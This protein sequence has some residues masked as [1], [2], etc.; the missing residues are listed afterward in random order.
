[1]SLSGLVSVDIIQTPELLGALVCV[2]VMDC[3]RAV[4]T[5]CPQELCPPFIRCRQL[6]MVR[7]LSSVHHLPQP[8]TKRLIRP[9][10]GS[11]LS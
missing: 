7:M 10:Q 6:T 1:M 4:G 3:R 8:R 11:N 5:A 9:Y 2:C